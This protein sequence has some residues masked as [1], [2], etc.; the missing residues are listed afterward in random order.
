MRGKLFK[1]VI[2]KI[3]QKHIEERGL[4]NASQF[5]FCAHH[6]VDHVIL[7]FNN[8]MS[9]AAVFFDVERAFDTTWHPGLLHKLPKLEFVA[10]LIQLISSFLLQSQGNCKQGC[11]KIPS[12]PQL[13]TVCM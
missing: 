6:S 2:I 7:N 12:Y 8:N 4:L 9:M 11:F 3:V 5:G 10:S 1:K 13:C